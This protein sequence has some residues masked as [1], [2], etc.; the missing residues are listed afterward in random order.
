MW[1]VVYP[2]LI[3]CCKSHLIVGFEIKPKEFCL[4]Q[5]AK[6]ESVDLV[7]KAIW[8]LQD[9][10]QSVRLKKSKLLQYHTGQLCSPNH[11]MVGNSTYAVSSHNPLFSAFYFATLWLLTV[12]CIRQRL[13]TLVQTPERPD[14][15]SVSFRNLQFAVGKVCGML[16]E[17]IFGRLSEVQG[18]DRIWQTC[19]LMLCQ[20]SLFRLNRQE[21]T[22][23]RG[24]PR[25]AMEEKLIIR[26]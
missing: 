10:Q 22:E 2:D 21:C 18:A 24:G 14:L 12:I 15:S 1:L 19:E 11:N 4:L 5:E 9:N 25:P 7:F 16:C 20:T 26:R 6:Y 8:L 13:V 23:I 17:S 3:L